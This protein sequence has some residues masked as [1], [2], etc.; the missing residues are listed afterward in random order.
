MKSIKSRVA[1]TALALGIGAT[2]ALGATVTAGE[3]SAKVASG[4][5][6]FTSTSLL[7]GLSDRK[8]VMI[9]G[10]VMTEYVY[11]TKAHTRLVP[12]RNGAYYDAQPGGRIVL[13]KRAHGRY[14]GY[15]ALL[16]IHTH[17]VK[18]TPRR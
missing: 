14:S 4:N 15:G 5:Y 7:S 13:T 9:K 6:W 18:L 11:G 1:A 2:A 17:S 8:P 16:G 12:T 3:A 10:N